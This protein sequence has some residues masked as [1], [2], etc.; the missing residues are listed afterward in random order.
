[1][2][3]VAVGG[4]QAAVGDMH[5]SNSP[6]VMC[7][8]KPTERASPGSVAMPTC[9]FEPCTPPALE[10][11]RA[12]EYATPP[13]DMPDIDEEVDGAPLWFRTVADLLG[14]V[15]PQGAT[16]TRHKEELLAAIVTEPVSVDEVLKSGAWLE[17]LSSIKENETWSLVK[18][19]RGHKAISL[20]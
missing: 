8:P 15:P 12:V 19:P 16:D 11:S 9:G 6:L 14:V 4:M 17:E 18:L 7:S 10:A 5:W 20:K 13:V 3:Y 2:E 1:M